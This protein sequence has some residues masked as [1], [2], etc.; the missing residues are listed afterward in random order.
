MKIRFVKRKIFNAQRQAMSRIELECFFL[1]IWF[2]KET[3]MGRFLKTF[4]F[5]V[6]NIVISLE[7]LKEKKRVWWGHVF[8]LSFMKEILAWKFLTSK[9]KEF[10]NNRNEGIYQTFLFESCQ[11]P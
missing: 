10:A 2:G 7:I 8:F 9:S 1:V 4:L 3:C 11:R 6:M 5:E